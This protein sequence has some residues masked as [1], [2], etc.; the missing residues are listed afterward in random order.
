MRGIVHK[1]DKGWVLRCLST[2]K[3]LVLHPPGQ[4]YK[5]AVYR[6][7]KVHPTDIHK[8]I[9]GKEMEYYVIRPFSMMNQT[10]HD[11]VEIHEIVEQEQ[12][13]ADINALHDLKFTPYQLAYL[14]AHYLPPEKINK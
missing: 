3:H 1:T 6:E 13:W 9:E 12:T 8:C 14:E 5:N 4:E 10:T 7:I 11:L 2:E